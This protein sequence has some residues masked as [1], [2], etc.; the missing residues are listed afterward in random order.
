ML[1]TILVS[2]L[3]FAGHVTN[4]QSHSKN[5]NVTTNQN[6][7]QLFDAW[8]L[9][10]AVILVTN[11]GQKDLADQGVIVVSTSIKNPT[12]KDLGVELKENNAQ[13]VRNADSNELY[14]VESLFR[15]RLMYNAVK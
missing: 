7:K 2:G 12:Y 15:L 11:N 10:N 8:C 13:Y 3:L 14:K 6:E 9:D 4:A 1:R 5:G